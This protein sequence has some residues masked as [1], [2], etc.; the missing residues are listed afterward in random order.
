[1]NSYCDKQDK[2]CLDSVS[3]ITDKS[4]NVAE[5]AKERK[6]VQL[7]HRESWEQIEK[8]KRSECLDQLKERM[9]EHK[10]SMH[11][12]LEEFETMEGDREEAMAEIIK[13]IE[14]GKKTLESYV[15][16]ARF[17]QRGKFELIVSLFSFSHLKGYKS[18]ISASM[19]GEQ[20]LNNLDPPLPPHPISLPFKVNYRLVKGLVTA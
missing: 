16:V 7:V 1:M 19:T 20:P 5:R 15:E 6:N 8:R 17:L 14:E 2:Q 9:K 12:L 13:F 4:W 10:K 3:S 18:A 11:K